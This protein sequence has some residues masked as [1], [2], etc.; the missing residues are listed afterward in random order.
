MELETECEGFFS[1]PGPGLYGGG[2]PTVG[3]DRIP[4]QQRRISALANESF[5]L[6]PAGD[7]AKQ[8]F[9]HHSCKRKRFDSTTVIIKP[10]NT[11]WV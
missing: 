3:D 10:E 8:T 2:I 4:S 11:L 5:P 1:D 6:A 7:D 9:N